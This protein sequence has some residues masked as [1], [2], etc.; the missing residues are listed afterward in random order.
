MRVL[1]VAKTRQGRG[2][3]I[4]A[5]TEDGRSVRLIGPDAAE[6]EQQGM[7]Y[8]VGDVWQVEI[9]AP[10]TVQPPHTENV[11]VRRRKR[12][13]RNVDPL[14]AIE[15]FMG[16]PSG[17]IEVLYEGLAQESPGGALY[18]AERVGVPPYSAMFW[19]PDQAL[20]RTDHG[21]RIRYSYPTSDG[22]RTLVFVGFQ[23]PV[24]EIPAYTLLRLSLAQW[25]RP[26]DQPDKELRCYVQLS[27][28]YGLE[29]PVAVRPCPPVPAIDPRE[30]LRTVFGYREF[31]P[32]QE[33]IVSRVLA[34]HPTLAVMP[35]GSGKSLCYQ[36]PALVFAGLTVVVSPLIS[37]M[38]DQV[39][40][41]RTLGVPAAFLNSSLDYA[42]YRRTMKLVRQGTIKVLY[43]AP[44]TLLRPETLRLLDEAGVC[45][46]AVDEGHCIS[47]WGHDFRPEYRRLTQVRSRY[48]QA[49]C[50]AL[51]ATATPRVQKDI[52]SHLLID[53]SQ[54]F[55]ASFDRANLF[56]EVAPRLDGE[57]QVLAF[58]RA[59]PKQSGIIYC[60]TKRQVDGLSAMLAK[61]GVS[62]LP[63]H[64]DLDASTRAENQRRF[65]RDD[66]QVMVATIAFGMGIDKPDVRFVLHYSVPQDLETYYQQIGRAGRDGLR[67]DCL[68]L[69]SYADVYVFRKF[70]E[71]GAEDQARGRQLRLKAML[72]WATSAHCRRRQLLSYFGESEPSDGCKMCDNCVAPA[73]SHTGDD[74]T[75]LAHQYLSCVLQTRERFG[76]NHVILVLRGSRAEPVLRWRHDRLPGYGV[77]SHLSTAEWK[78]LAQQ[79]LQQGLLIQDMEYGHLS[80]TDRGRAVLK[81]K[82][83]VRGIIQPRQTVSRAQPGPEEGA[84]D[85]DL[86]EELRR[87]RKEL[88]DGSRVPP[89][90]VFHDRTLREIATHRP[91]S[92]ASLAQ[93]HGVG[94]HKLERYG[95][96]VLRLV[97]DYCRQHGSGER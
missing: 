44:E 6:D 55:T 3:C 52:C 7:D 64:A 96:A 31:R 45:C 57:A 37:L 78:Q 59:H 35:T 69:F 21:V 66:V 4:G 97:R 1:V 40:Q 49:A 76:V 26:P 79:F 90:V 43:V 28:W 34:G 27:G 13:R 92:E 89:Y 67:A 25:W 5:L 46:L 51:T 18:I 8:E 88:A 9:G 65:I 61:R 22:R 39:D 11:I 17:G 74:L 93:L 14:P 41:L 63:Y 84:Y 16:A 80:L 29:A 33:E 15:K 87:L 24:P 73:D 54:V 10:D 81:D 94:Q 53:A 82:M 60:S 58:V 95:P 75:V 77:G 56:L 12:L 72:R 70:I 30:R 2:A 62:A 91:R 19:R 42:A 86:F 68:L 38:Q 36:L 32:L 23:E 85:S 48:P 50:L 47:E 83:T 20:Q 71:E